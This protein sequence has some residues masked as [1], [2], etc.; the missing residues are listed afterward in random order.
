MSRPD[1][2]DAPRKRAAQS[3]PYRRGVGMMLLNGHGRVLIGK[4][5]D[6]AAGDA[7][8]MPQ[9]G[10]D[11]DEEPAQAVWRELKEEVGTDK[12][13]LIAE[14]RDWL[15]YDFPAELASTLWGGRFRGQMHR[16]FL[17]RFTGTAAD[18]A[19]DTHE[20]EFSETRWVEPEALPNMVVWFKRDNYRKVLAE[21]AA[22]LQKR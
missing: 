22:Y 5:I 4:R 6:T 18:L 20:R 19:L 3:L 10:I 21:F 15:R 1:V 12:A 2:Q 7:W 9:G 13:T 14:A 8:Q 17:L 11:A 16:W